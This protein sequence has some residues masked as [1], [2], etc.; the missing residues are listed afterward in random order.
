[1]AKGKNAAKNGHHREYWSWRPFSGWGW[2]K[3]VK[4]LTHRQERRVLAKREIKE[5][6][7]G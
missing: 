4:T 7:D 5:Q 6:L 1:M 3:W 2:G